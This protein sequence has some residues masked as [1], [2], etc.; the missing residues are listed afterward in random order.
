M[1][2]LNLKSLGLV[3][4]V[5]FATGGL[6]SA[7]LIVNGGFETGNFDGWTHTPFTSV[8]SFGVT[9]GEPHTGNYNAYFE[10]S[11]SDLDAISQTF[12]TTAGVFY[13]LSFWLANPFGPSD[14]EFR[15][16]FGGV[17]VQDLI[18]AGIFGYTPYSFSVLGTGSPLTLEFAGRNGGAFFDLDDVSVEAR[19]ATAPE[20]GS[21]ALLLGAA[22]MGLILI[23][24][25]TR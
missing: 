24:R 13:D 11:G 8:S 2:K 19:S 20:A 21:S 12:A 9:T 1:N 22:L 10:T 5:L 23:Q 7:N 14:N 16:T 18:N 15:V 17:V 25:P 3:V 6:A 4:I